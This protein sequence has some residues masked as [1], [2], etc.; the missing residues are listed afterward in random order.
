MDTCIHCDEAIVVPVYAEEDHSRGQA[1]CCEGCLTVFQVLSAKGLSEYYEIKR[2][3]AHF[4]RRA[5]VQTKQEAYLYLD[6]A[7]FEKD[8]AEFDENQKSMVFYLEGIH[9]LACLWLIE[10]LDEIV[11]GVIS[12]KLNLEK[13]TCTVVIKSEGKFSSVAKELAAL[14]YTPHALKDEASHSLQKKAERS[15]LKRLGIAGAAAGNIMIYAVSLYGG[16]AGE[17]AR[18][19]NLL[20]VVMAI[21]VLTYSAWPFYQSA[22][23][24]LKNK[25]IS[26]DVPISLALLMGGCMGIFNMLTGVP[27]NYF[28]SLTTLVF[29]LLLSRY[30]LRK[31]QEQGLKAQDLHFFYQV[32]SVRRKVGADQFEDIHPRYLSIGDEIE[33]CPGSFLPAD[34]IILE[35][36]SQV[37]TSLLTGESVSVRVQKGDHVFS[38]TENLTTRFLMKVQKQAGDSRL[39]KILTNVE[40]GWSHRSRT[41]DVT[42]RVSKW[43][44]LTVFVLSA[45]AFFYVSQTLGTREGIIRALTLLI[46]TCPCALALSVPLTFN[47]S[48]SLAA[49]NGIIVKSDEVLEKLS[50]K[51]NIYLDKTGTLTHGHLILEKFEVIRSMNHR[52]EDVIGSLE[53]YSQHPVARVLLTYA[54]SRSCLEMQVENLVERRGVGVSGLVDGNFYEIK[55]SAIFENG[56]LCCLFSVRDTLRPESKNVVM[57]LREESLSLCILSGDT[58]KIVNEMSRECGIETFRA[59]LSPE[60]KLSII[61]ADQHSVMI[62]DGANDAMALEAAGVGIAVWGAM[63]ISLRAADVYLTTPGLLLV[64]K[65]LVL[66]RETM[67]VIHRN[68]FVSILYNITSVVFVFTGKIDPLVAAIIMPVSSLTVLLSSLWGTKTLRSVWKS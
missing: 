4:R 39:G 67:K 60:D 65:L 23:S 44:T 22:W 10:K 40:N 51:Q 46:V 33:V 26:I 55:K 34:G 27:E 14:G 68:L 18:I 25:T 66:S 9:C 37:D 62:G 47:R 61:K 49:Q 29:L 43:F 2:L 20:T 5:P 56:K 54:R 42:A 3:S 59:E 30:F 13:S 24:S 8:H 36:E 50:Q 38:G 45:G 7:Q 52:P 63:D 15:S 53:K 32:E 58:T 21:P 28:D 16:A 35:G 64:H 57:K 6:D 31:V 12:S 48:L 11:D 17:Y 41:V 1:F 19:F